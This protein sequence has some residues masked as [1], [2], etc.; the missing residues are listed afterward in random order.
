MSRM[1]EHRFTMPTVRPVEPHRT[2]VPI[3]YA[4]PLNQ[5]QL[6]E[7]SLLRCPRLD[8]DTGLP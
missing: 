6:V 5:R 3:R 4:R 8:G 1:S 2:A 7:Q